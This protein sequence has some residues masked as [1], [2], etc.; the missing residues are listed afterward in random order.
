M[1]AEYVRNITERKRLEE[2]VRKSHKLESLGILA[3]GIAH[4]FNN[5]LTGILGNISL[6]KLKMSQEDKNYLRLD[7]AE[8]AAERARDLTQQLLTFSRGGA[9]IKKTASIA[10]IVMDSASFVLR[11]SNVKCEFVIPDYVWPVEADEGQMNQVINNLIINADQAMPEGGKINVTVA[12]LTVGPKDILTVKEGRYVRISIEDHGIGIAEQHLQKI[13]DPYF[14]TKQKG[15][16][17]GLATVYSI[18]KNHDGYILVE[19][20]VGTGTAFKIYLPASENEIPVKNQPGENPLSGSGKILIMDDE[21]ILREVAGEILSHLGYRVVVCSEGSEAI[22]L[23][24]GA[25]RSED[26]FAAV[27]MDLTIP[28]GMGGKETMRKLQEIDSGVK[29]IVSSGY[30]ND[31]ILANYLEYGFI[32]V[33]AK[34]YNMEELGRVLRDTLLMG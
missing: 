31:P 10:Q 18:I 16:G 33:V 30:C 8:K 7:S 9:P 5:L 6:A 29:G 14:T 27:I 13:F 34:P 25:M 26:P 1:V 17:L 15:S 11:G 22:S 19:S 20:T 23:Y 2:E 24:Q 28:G 21:E 12:N 32:S 3:G 4:D